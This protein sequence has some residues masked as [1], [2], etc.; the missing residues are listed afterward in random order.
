MSGKLMA[1]LL[2]VPALFVAA[3]ATGSAVLWM[4]GVLLAVVLIASA[5]SVRLNAGALKIRSELAESRIGRGR[6]TDLTLS[7]QSRR[8]LPIAPI[9]LTVV[10]A[11]AA[12]PLE[13][14]LE[15]VRG[16]QQ[17]TVPL[18][19]EHCGSFTPGAAEAR[20]ED[21]FGFFRRR[22]RPEGK[23]P[24]LLVLPEPFE[25]AAL[26]FAPGDAGWDVLARASEDTSN[27]SDFRAYQPGDALKK[28]HWKL[29]ARK[30]EL[31]VRRFDEPVLPEALVLLDCSPPPSLGHPEAEA[32][33][34]DA[35][36]ETAASVAV[37]QM[38]E[39][40]EVRLPLPGEQPV[41]LNKDSGEAILL[42]H[43]ARQHFTETDRFER[44]L[45]METRRLRT[46]GATVVI[47]AR[48]SSAM[49]DV[50]IRMR[51]MG[52]NLR[53]HLI[54]YT[55]GDPRV[56]KLTDQLKQADIEVMLVSPHA[57]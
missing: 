36:L 50:M 46:V 3:L 2:A 40:N 31:I 33:L 43:L 4:A 28:I 55:E 20:I 22:V 7:V 21:I 29:S 37:K 27:P 9:T 47:S 6:D 48:I 10:T 24:E 12:E 18:H 30:G 17:I 1:A 42:E 39:G 54:T 32:D 51:R 19:A 11:Q 26:T 52:P 25:T 8:L 53:F 35:L 16:G 38:R 5:V 44:V 56:T 49:V 15:P 23:L 13:I 34:R 14:R 41:E 57:A 45:L